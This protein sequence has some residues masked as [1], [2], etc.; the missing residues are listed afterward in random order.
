MGIAEASIKSRASRNLER[1]ILGI[2]LGVS[3]FIV[4]LI[5]DPV[6]VGLL[7][8]QPESQV[9]EVSAYVALAFALV[10]LCILFT[11]ATTILGSRTRS[12][13]NENMASTVE[14]LSR[15][16]SD[17]SFLRVLPLASVVY[18]VFYA[19]ASGIIVYHPDVDFQ[20][21]YHVSVPSLA[22]ATCCAPLGQTPLAVVYL[23]QHIG[24][25]LVPANLLLLFSLSW[26]VGLNAALG[27]FLF[28][29]RANSNGIGWVGGVGA[30]VG[31]FTA[32][33]TCAGLAVLSIL[34][35]TG[36]L[37]VALFL[38]PLQILFVGLSVP[39]LVASPILLA[40]S[41]RAN[42]ART[43]PMP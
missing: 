12:D 4:G 34:G 19:F 36:A 33:P 24:L 38:G 26:L 15:I 11:S 43:C 31:L 2:L 39:L 7:A 14:T 8:V 27:T 10:G 22:V 37:S 13:A 9:A 28:S 32:C 3:V 6:L 35:G 40:R 18:G 16:L 17:A 42:K 20:T 25:L 21:V 23:T 29:G 5:L 1:A 41:L 30:M